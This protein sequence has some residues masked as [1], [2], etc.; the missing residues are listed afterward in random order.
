[1]A[2][3]ED[4]VVLEIGAGCSQYVP[5]LLG[6][7][8]RKY[9]ANDLI[10]ER[11][12]AVRPDDPRWIEIPGDFLEID[13]PEPVDVVLANLVMM[14]LVPLH[15]E[16]LA[17]VGSILRSGGVFLS[18][19]TNYL[20]PLS[21]VRRFADRKPNPARLFNPFTYRRLVEAQGLRVERM[22]PFT[23]PVPWVTGN[24]LLGT[25]FWLRARKP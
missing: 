20:C 12:A 15:R 18:M 25:T 16:I 6:F 5:V 17:K 21:I 2:D 8:C 23:G 1:A 24:W 11:L 22:V 14:Q 9:F 13:V 10:P 19:D 7:G 4:K 3:F